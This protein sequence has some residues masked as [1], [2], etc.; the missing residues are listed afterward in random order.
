M[1]QYLPIKMDTW[2]E[3]RANGKLHGRVSRETFQLEVMRHGQ[4]C[5]YD[6]RATIERG[7]V[8]FIDDRDDPDDQIVS[9]E[10]LSPV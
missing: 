3:L 7:F 2:I 6:L 8:V 1:Q 9:R 5:V 4:R 10:T